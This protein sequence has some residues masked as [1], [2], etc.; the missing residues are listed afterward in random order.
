MSFPPSF[1]HHSFFHSRRDAHGPFDEAPLSNTCSL[2][3]VFPKRHRLRHTHT[4]VH[5]HTHPC[6]SHFL[7]WGKLCLLHK[8]GK[9]EKRATSSLAEGRAVQE[10][11][12]ECESVSP[13]HC[14]GQRPSS[15]ILVSHR[16]ILSVRTGPVLQAEM[17]HCIGQPTVY[18]ICPMLPKLQPI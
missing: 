9:R 3:S 1:T 11:L 5:T 13:Q 6:Q 14:R 18:V 15:A 4:H 12:E 16:A 17:K 10:A 8:P 2:P 7:I